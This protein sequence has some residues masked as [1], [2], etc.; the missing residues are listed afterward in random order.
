MG[1]RPPQGASPPLPR[2]LPLPR[3]ASGHS[4][5]LWPAFPGARRAPLFPSQ[6]PGT[7]GL[8]WPCPLFPFGGGRLVLLHGLLRVQL[9]PPACQGHPP[10]QKWRSRKAECIG[11]RPHHSRSRRDRGVL[12]CEGQREGVGE[13]RDPPSLSRLQA[14]LRVILQPPT[15]SFLRQAKDPPPAPLHCTDE[16]QRVPTIEAVTPAFTRLDRKEAPPRARCWQLAHP[17]DG[18]PGRQ[19]PRLGAGLGDP[20]AGGP[21]RVPPAAQPPAGR[22]FLPR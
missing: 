8:T 6:P 4:P 3:G 2:L 9:L 20:P 19:A 15:P 5:S 18:G 1:E 21:G 16:G 10:P 7:P 12:P 13:G 22:S 14:Q 17:T 11:S